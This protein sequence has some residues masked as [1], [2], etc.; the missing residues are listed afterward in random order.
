DRE[1]V[2]RARAS[3]AEGS[4]GAARRRGPPARPGGARLVPERERRAAILAAQHLYPRRRALSSRALREADEDSAPRR[5]GL[6]RRAMADLSPTTFAQDP[7]A[8]LRDYSRDGF[9][10]EHGLFSAAECDRLIA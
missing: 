2:R 1:G 10:V 7:E 6:R 5:P 9:F 3:G 4:R 8:A